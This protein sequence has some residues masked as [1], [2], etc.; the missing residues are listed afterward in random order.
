MRN[1]KKVLR[2]RKRDLPITRFQE[3]FASEEACREY[4]F[5]LKWP[6]GFI[7]PKCGHRKHYFV[8]RG[9][10][11]QCQQCKKQTSITAGTLLHRSHLP[12]VKW[13][14]AMYLTSRDKRGCSA[15]SLKN[16]I[17]ISYPTAWLL[18]Q[19]IRTAMVTKERDYILSGV[20]VIDDAY[21]GGATKDEK[22]GRRTEKSKVLVSISLN[23][24]GAPMFAKMKVVENLK[25]ETI[26]SAVSEMVAKGSILRSDDYKSFAT[27]KDFVHEVVIA[28]KDKETARSILKWADIVIANSK[29]FIIGTYH[30]LPD[31][32]LGTYLDEFCY[33]FNRR[34][35]EPLIFGKLVRACVSTSQI[36]YAELT[37]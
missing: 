30:G 31:K 22:R 33:R 18:L 5:Q 20:V 13:F 9:Q 26:N 8:R 36:T 29:A 4:L 28:S 23:K 10:L 17:Q 12:L 15:L 16:M 3:I 1:T 21:Y 25:S 19:K 11:Y 6:K 7:C 27:I 37:L 32:H 24:Q 35:C 14:W 2:K 34:F